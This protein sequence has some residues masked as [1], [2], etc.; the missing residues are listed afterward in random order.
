[1]YATK[2]PNDTSDG[3]QNLEGIY[4]ND[5][6]NI[7]LQDDANGQEQEQ[8][9]SIL[10]PE[11]NAIAEIKLRIQNSL[12]ESSDQSQNSAQTPSIRNSGSQ[13]FDLNRHPIDEEEEEDTLFNLVWERD[14]DAA[15]AYLND[16]SMTSQQLRNSLYFQNEDGWN[17]LMRAFYRRPPH[18]DSAPDSLIRQMVEMGGKDLVTM[19]N[20]WGENS[21]IYA[22]KNKRSL[23]VIRLLLD[24]GGG[25]EFVLQ[26]NFRGKSPLHVACEQRASVEV[27][28]SLVELGGRELVMMEDD[29][30]V[31]ARSKSV[32]IMN[33]L[34]KV[35]GELKNKK[36]L[37]KRPTVLHDLI[38]DKMFDD[39]EQYLD[40]ERITLHGKRS[41]M[42]HKDKD[43]FTPLMLSILKNAPDSLLEKIVII[44]G[45][46]I[47]AMTNKWDNIALVYALA[48]KRTLNI[49]CLMVDKGGGKESIAKCYGKGL[50]PVSIIVC[51]SC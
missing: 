34:E 18:Y 4:N 49:I 27:V 42:A 43:G 40:D 51:F 38:Q 20:I 14:F 28:Q 37:S 41:A 13:S 22:L 16:H 3:V 19:T 1:M 29:V 36:R 31:V 35:S 50:T 26:Q 17:A 44:G 33:Y 2:A 24:V 45:S 15:G 32:D 47:L 25:K 46:E 8:E 30:G 6:D 7:Q 23:Y 39:A 5:I 10:S 21:L 9:S 12:S 11:R 48:Q